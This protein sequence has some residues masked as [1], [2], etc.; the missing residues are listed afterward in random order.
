LSGGRSS[1]SGPNIELAIEGALSIPIRSPLSLFDLILISDSLNVRG[2]WEAVGLGPNEEVLLSGGW[3]WNDGRG[4]RV[5]WNGEGSLWRLSDGFGR[6]DVSSTTVTL[7]MAG[8][9]GGGSSSEECGVFVG[10]ERFTI[11]MSGLLS[12]CVDRSIAGDSGGGMYKGGGEFSWF[13]P[14]VIPIDLSWGTGDAAGVFDIVDDFS[15]SESGSWFWSIVECRG[16]D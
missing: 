11:S 7:I 9:R 2:E 6:G 10:P 13:D 14:G 15:V 8:M 3:D 16:H 1:P 12:L 4:I 5:V